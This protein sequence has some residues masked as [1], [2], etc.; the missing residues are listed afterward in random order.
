MFTGNQQP[1]IHTFKATNKGVYKGTIHYELVSGEPFLESKKINISKDRQCAKSTPYYWLKIRES[2]KW[3]ANITGLF[4]TNGK[5][6]F[7]GDHNK[8]ESLILFK[9]SDNAET[10]TVFFY[11]NY[12][13]GDL[14]EVLKQIQ[15]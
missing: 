13:T 10:L 9:F 8:R 15:E 12:F 4:P 1:T 3:S 2:K 5:Y 14:I 7:K 11:Q 6:I